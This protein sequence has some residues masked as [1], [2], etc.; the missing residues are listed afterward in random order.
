MHAHA[1]C[2]LDAER[3]GRHVEEQ[4]VLRLRRR[5]A[6]QNTGLHRCPVRD[7]LVWID[8]LVELFS[9]EEFLEQ[10][11]HLWH[12]RRPPD[13]NNLMHSGFVHLRVAQHLGNG[14]HGP[15]EQI[16]AELLKLCARNRLDEIEA[17]AQRF[18]LHSG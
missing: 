2:R 12:A 7:R 4:K 16:G 13:K 17:G 8:A 6:R 5:T 3:E 14:R 15:F 1:A 18:Q 10:L 9:V 11:L